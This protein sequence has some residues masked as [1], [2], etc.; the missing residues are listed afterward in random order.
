MVTN[1]ESIFQWLFFNVILALTPVI[2]ILLVVWM[3]DLN[4]RW[5]RVLRGGELYIF[6]TTL[7]ATSISARLFD[8]KPATDVVTVSI[9][10]LVVIMLFATGLFAL[11]AYTQLQPRGLS[12]RVSWRIS[13]TSIGCAVATSVLSYIISI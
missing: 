3:F 13:G 9:A 7:A 10:A 8:T 4:T 2:F 1:S 6:S 11:S 5:F 12:D